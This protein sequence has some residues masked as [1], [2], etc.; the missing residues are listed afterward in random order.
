M[1]RDL[2]QGEPPLAAPPLGCLPAAKLLPMQ[3]HPALR[4]RDDLRDFLRRPE[5]VAH[6]PTVCSLALD[7]QTP[8]KEGDA[9]VGL[10]RAGGS[11]RDILM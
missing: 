3:P 11:S 2:G 5:L 10:L 8:E 1:P 9:C 7:E 6:Q 4:E